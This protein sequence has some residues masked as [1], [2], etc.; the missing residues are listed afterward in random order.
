MFVYEYEAKKILASYDITIP[1]QL[2]VYQS[3]DQLSDSLQYPAVAKV[4]IL[5]GKRGKR[6]GIKIINSKLEL[7]QFCSKIFNQKFCKLGKPA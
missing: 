7:E 4:Q 6:G 1:E 2:A 5:Q 3:E